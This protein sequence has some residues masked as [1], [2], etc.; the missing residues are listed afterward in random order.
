MIRRFSHNP[1]SLRALTLSPG[2]KKLSEEEAAAVLVLAQNGHA[3]ALEKLLLNYA[4][5]FV[6]AALRE[7]QR[8][9]AYGLSL[10]DL[11]NTLVVYFPE[12]TKK[13]R[14]AGKFSSYLLTC[15]QNRIRIYIMENRSVIS[16][17]WGSTRGFREATLRL[18]QGAQSP[19]SLEELQEAGFDLAA[20]EEPVQDESLVAP[21]HQAVGKLSPINRETVI[22]YF[23]L[24]CA[25]ETG[26]E[27]ASY[28][29]VS[30]GCVKGRLKEAKERLRRELEGKVPLRTVAA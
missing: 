3:W 24:G 28:L 7:V 15:L 8:A 12:I 25:R 1:L 10:D 13:Y 14:Q 20:G 27:I 4:N 5:C 30:Q 16:T 19:A 2:W 11:I 23:G 22:R 6:V 29:G 21:V 17:P 26:P 18:M 9:E